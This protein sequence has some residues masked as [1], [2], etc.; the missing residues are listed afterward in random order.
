MFVYPLS[1]NKGN[2]PEKGISLL[3]TS[4]EDNKSINELINDTLCQ[5]EALRRA[6]YKGSNN[7]F[8]ILHLKEE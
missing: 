4:H 5:Y 3:Y 1:C 8:F 2:F 6:Y 7:V